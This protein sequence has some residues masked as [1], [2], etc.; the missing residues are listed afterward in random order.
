VIGY[1]LALL[2]ML[3]SCSTAPREPVRMWALLFWLAL[4]FTGVS[5]G[6]AAVTTFLIRSY[7]LLCIATYVVNFFMLWYAWLIRRRFS[8]S[9]LLQDT[10]ADLDFMREHRRTAFLFGGPWIL[11]VTAAVLL[12]PAYWKIDPPELPQNVPT[13]MTA[14]G[15]PWT[16]ARNP[17]IEIEIFSDYQCFQCKKMHQFLR[18]LV[19]RHS[20]SIRLVHRQFPMDHEV[21]PMVS[22]PFHPGSGKMALLAIYAAKQNRFARMDDLLFK[23]A[24]GRKAID[25]RWLADKAGLE[26]K[27]LVQSLGDPSS[28]RL[29]S[30]DIREGIELGIKGTPSFVVNGKIYAGVIP[31]EILSRYLK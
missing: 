23:I 24:G 14:E 5:I 16:G 21:N 28:R 3:P 26:A 4:G 1:V 7:C 17:E 10:R 12:T 11:A 2:L 9:G 15:H 19:A 31:A 22:E 13:G 6:L 20:D 8:R 27:A 25:L 18:R 30:R 29:L